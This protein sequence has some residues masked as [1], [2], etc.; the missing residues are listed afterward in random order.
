MSATLGISPVKIPVWHVAKESYSSV[1]GDPRSFFKLVWPPAFLGYA[2]LAPSFYLFFEKI[3]ASHGTLDPRTF[4]HVFRWFDGV[5]L[6]ETAIFIGFLCLFAVGWHRWRLLG[7]QDNHTSPTFWRAWLRF[8]GYGLLIWSPD[9]IELILKIAHEFDVWPADDSGVGEIVANLVSIASL[10]ILIC[11][12]CCSL[13]FPAAAL[14]RPL[15]LLEA[16]R[17]L[18][19][20]F[21]RLVACCALTGALGFVTCLPIIIVVMAL[22]PGIGTAFQLAMTAIGALYEFVFVALFA[23]ILSSFYRQIGLLGAGSR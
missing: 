1:F 19:G 7:E 10:L 22:T 17:R 2:T 21:W 18:R 14:D 8:T 3:E 12:I 4:G 9:F 6:L 20:N 11:G 15:T 5:S 13:I 16:W 23:S